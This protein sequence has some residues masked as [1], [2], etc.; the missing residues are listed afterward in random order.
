[1]SESICPAIRRHAV[2]IKPPDR[3]TLESGLTL[4]PVEVTYETY[5]TL[6]SA[7]DN[8]ILVCHALT[9]DA[10]AAGRYS[11]EDEIPGWWDDLIGP[12][13][14]LDTDR[15]YVICSNVLGGCRGTTGPTSINP[16]TGQPHGAD[17]PIVTI[18]DMVKLQKLLL[19]SLGVK[20]LVTVIGG[21]MGGMQVLEWAVTYPDFMASAIAMAV[22]AISTAQQIAF[23][24][25]GRR[26]IW[27]DPEWRGGHYY[28]GD[29]PTEGLSIARAVGTI[30]YK[31]DHLWNER[32]GRRVEFAGDPFSRQ[33][34]FSIENY[35]AY[36]GEKLERRFDANSYL[37]LL[38]A[39]D[40]HN[41]GRGRTASGSWEEALETVSTRLLIVGI[42][43]DILYPTY[44]QHEMV[45]TL[46]RLKKE[47]EYFELDS[48]YGHDSFLIEF[49]IMNQAVAEFLDNL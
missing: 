33:G 48:P 27:L 8:A 34:R 20:R 28:P 5:G 16:L 37:Y 42:N 4:S 1:M 13:K 45:C 6:N 3:L 21:S 15:Y 19:D 31:S 41:L 18:R 14:A 29:G 30:T 44:Q 35:L 32:F 2:L 17:F 36:Q 39:M 24:D 11:P 26:A 43:S 9:G 25:V 40:L 22:S 38:R 7:G 46:R 49:K 12:G 10:H 47:V 23:N